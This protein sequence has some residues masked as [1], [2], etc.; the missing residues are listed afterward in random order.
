MVPYFLI[1]F[2]LY[3]LFMVLMYYGWNKTEAS[4]YEPDPGIL[5]YASVI[6]AVRNE[7]KNIGRLLDS[8]AE[9]TLDTWRFEVIFVDDHSEDNTAIEIEK[10]INSHE[11]NMHLIANDISSDHDQSPKKTALKKG[12]DLAKGDVIIMTDG[13][14]WF[15]NEWLLTMVSAFSSQD[16]MFV[17][18]PVVISDH[19]KILTN[20]QAL[21][22]SS[23]MGTGAAM[24]TLKYPLMCNGANIAFRK[25]TFYHV[26]GYAGNTQHSTGDDVFLMQKIHAAYKDSVRFI[27][28][29][30]A[31]VSTFAQP[32]LPHLLNQ[33][34]RWASK[35]KDYLLPWS[36]ILPIFLFVHYLSF[37]TGIIYAIAVPAKALEIGIMILLKLILD[38]IFLKKV[39]DFCILRL[40]LSVFILTE[41]LYPFYAIYTGIT[42]HS[43]DFMWKKRTYKV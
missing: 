12:I 18:G 22:F 28:N 32:T 40:D 3:Y 14:C 10:F 39:M 29:P 5:P 27:K 4:I 23:L 20:M 42:V 41:I 1:I 43:G 6:I 38:Y 17:S 7:E 19:G 34:K 21:E 13:D 36:N 2:S 30:A 8:L 16:T 25:E 37:L 31:I 11:I 24:I 35:W 26:N 15:D 9:Q 33:R